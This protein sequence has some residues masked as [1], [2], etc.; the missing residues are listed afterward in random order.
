MTI[1]MKK[2]YSILNNPH[3]S[4]NYDKSC[5]KDTYKRR[6]WVTGILKNMS[7]GNSKEIIQVLTHGR[8]AH[9]T[10]NDKLVK[11]SRNLFSMPSRLLLLF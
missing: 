3:I 2:D 6:S 5:K 4:K 8:D 1:S 11:G 7:R 10:T 9:P